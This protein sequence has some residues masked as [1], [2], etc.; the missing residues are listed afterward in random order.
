MDVSYACL[1]GAA[2]VP[3]DDFVLAGERFV[4]VLDG[5]TAPAGIDSGCVHDVPWLVATLASQ[6]ARL[7]ATEPVAPLR[8]VLRSA[9]LATMASHGSACDLTNRDSP[10]STVAV[11]R[12]HGGMLDYLVLGDSSIVLETH[13]GHIEVV[14][15]NRTD[16]LPSYTR[17]VVSAARNTPGGFWI[18]GSDPAAADHALTGS[19]PAGEVRRVVMLTDGASRVVERYGRTWPDTIELAD[20][21]GPARVIAEVR[22]G[23]AAS[24][25]G[26]YRGK[27]FDD[28]TVVLCQGFGPRGT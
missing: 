25:A 10:S 13:A 5:A 28:A 22:A 17:E 15:D 14:H 23:D 12:E 19:L 26:A 8:Q 7:L 2:E 1:P 16:F 24:P 18:A 11:L 20:K 9:I 3:N 27:R 6:L 4:I 21:E